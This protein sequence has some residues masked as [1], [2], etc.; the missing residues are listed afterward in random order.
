MAELREAVPGPLDGERLD[1]VVAMLIDRPRA[2]VDALLAAGAVRLGA[3]VVTKGSRKVRAGERLTV[4]LPDP[5]IDPAR[6]ADPDV[7]V[8]VVHVDDAVVV[9]DKPAGMVVH[10]GAGHARGTLVQGLLAR[11]PDLAALATPGAEVRPGVVQRLDRGTSGLLVVARTVAARDDLVDQLAGREVERRYLALLAGEVEADEGVV[12]A[13]LGRSTRTATLMAVRADGRP[14]RTRYRVL[15]RLEGATFVEARLETGR[16]HQIRVHARA[17]G[18]PVIG[19]LRYGGPPATRLAPDRPFL[20]A[21]VLGFRHPATG[22]QV[23]FESPLPD[24]LTGELA[25]WR[26][27]GGGGA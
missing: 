15:Q 6:L 4:D 3:T 10:P 24:D 17:I 8:P 22:A 13:P 2:A 20:H 21:A 27:P 19:D 14:A 9:V 5:G 16:T 26:N 7:Q 11:Y 18:H 25:A 1:R 12:D 23:R